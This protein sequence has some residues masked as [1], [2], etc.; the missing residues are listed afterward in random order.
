[1]LGN[2][3]N[4]SFTLY[5]DSFQTSNSSS[6]TWVLCLVI[7]ELEY[8]ERVKME[9]LL[10]VGLTCEKPDLDLFLEPLYNSMMNLVKGVNFETPDQTIL[11][12]GIIICFIADQVAKAF[13]MHM[14]KYNGKFG[15]QTC[16][17]MSTYLEDDRVRVY[18]KAKFD[19]RTDAENLLHIAK[20]KQIQD[21]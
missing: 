2:R 5:T 1:M 12:K 21:S 13:M 17:I 7:N 20:S 6:E 14:T 8:T 15:C 9:N 3:N 10:I 19:L 11:V 16:T 18:K 4:I